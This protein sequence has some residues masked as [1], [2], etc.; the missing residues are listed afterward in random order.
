MERFTIHAEGVRA[1]G[2]EET[3]GI[4]H[5][6]GVRVTKARADQFFRTLVA[7]QIATTGS[8]VIHVDFR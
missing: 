2:I 6:A 1:P 8:T 4:I 3:G 5:A 7:T